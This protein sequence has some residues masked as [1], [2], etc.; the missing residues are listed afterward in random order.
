METYMCMGRG[1]E[2]IHQGELPGGGVFSDLRLVEMLMDKVK[3]GSLWK[4]SF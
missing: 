4:F 1:G 3:G 2:E